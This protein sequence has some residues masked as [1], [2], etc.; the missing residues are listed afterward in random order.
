VDPQKRLELLGREHP[1]VEQCVA[2]GYCATEGAPY[3]ALMVDSGSFVEGFMTVIHED[4]LDILDEHVTTGYVRRMI[5]LKN[6]K[7]AWTL[8]K[9]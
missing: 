2:D 1:Y 3:P 7:E 5:K 8:I 4:E 6:G 9:K